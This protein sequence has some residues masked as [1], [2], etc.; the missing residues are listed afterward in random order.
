MKSLLDLGSLWVS[1]QERQ[2]AKAGI[3]KV[4]KL[5]TASVTVWVAVHR[6]SLFSRTKNASRGLANTATS[7]VLTWNLHI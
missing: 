1:Y 3:N 5:L 6:K 2:A 7:V 4:L